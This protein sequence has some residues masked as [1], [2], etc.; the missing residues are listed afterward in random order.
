MHAATRVMYMEYLKEKEMTMERGQNYELFDM[1]GGD[2]KKN[3]GS[4]VCSVKAN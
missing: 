2:L 1:A 4:V 3:L